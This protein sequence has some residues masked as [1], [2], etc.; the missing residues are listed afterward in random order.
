MAVRSNTTPLSLVA[1]KPVSVPSSLDPIG[2]RVSAPDGIRVVMSRCIHVRNMRLRPTN[3]VQLIQLFFGDAAEVRNQFEGV[4]V[5][6]FVHATSSGTNRGMKYS[7]RGIEVLPPTGATETSVT[8]ILRNQDPFVWSLARGL[9]QEVT[10]I[11][12][13]Q[14]EEDQ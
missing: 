8:M 14:V 5:V 2:G 7:C 9:C 4:I 12:G 13:G 6:W 1:T 10:R 3:W 11:F